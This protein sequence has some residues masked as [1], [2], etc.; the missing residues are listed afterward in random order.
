MMMMMMMLTLLSWWM[1][2]NYMRWQ[3]GIR[4]DRSDTELIFSM[5]MNIKSMMLEKT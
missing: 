2:R 3:H 5:N 4:P 1:S